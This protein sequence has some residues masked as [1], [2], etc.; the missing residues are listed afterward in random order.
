MTTI[1]RIVGFAVVRLAD[2]AR[3]LMSR[4]ET[5]HRVTFL[6][7]FED[8]RWRFGQWRAWRAFE[9]ARTNTPAYREFLVGY[10]DARVALQGLDPD[11]SRVPAT[12]KENYVKRFSIEQRCVGGRLPAYGVVIDESSGTS[13]MPNNWVRGPHERRAVKRVL[14]YSFHH[15]FGREPIFVI[16]AFALGPWATGMNV[17]MSF[18]DVAILKSVGPD[19]GK[20]VNTLKLFGP[21][22][23]YLIM[24][25]PPF[26]K[27]MI[28]QADVN[29]AGYDVSAVYGGEGMSE[30]MRAYLGRAFREIIGSYGASDLEINIAA[31]S[32]FT[33]A[34]RRAMAARADLRAALTRTEYGVLPMVFQYNPMDYA[35]E[36]NEHGEL[37]V[38]LCRAHN[39]SPK[40]RYDIHDLG[41]VLRYPDLVRR[42]ATVGMHPRD[43]GAPH[44][45]LPL[46]FHYGR[47]D[48]AVAYYGSKVTPTN[49]EEALFSVPGLGEVMN[50]FALVVDEDAEANKTLTLAI[51]LGEG[52]EAPGDR[53][54]ARAAVLE[55]L[56]AINQDYREAQRF[57]PASARP[58]LEFHACGTGPFEGGD[59]RLKKH[60]IRT[61]GA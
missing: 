29:W 11:F 17:S 30:G 58:R 20:I 45:D 33:I 43:L 56:A 34:L 6:P 41:H 32:P 31:E 52:R 8:T 14:Q 28:D 21:R 60:Y 36:T 4:S 44:L 57:M 48:L 51:E 47:S 49:V 15:L 53:E 18:V 54:A 46:L 42:M 1:L 16:N 38:T 10:P 22:Y 61:A 26:L 12:D 13:G 23:R 9:R 27:T 19:V 50:S 24:G 37:L 5:A 7:G 2:V 55:R 40:I 3:A 25:Y 39:A 59:I 35:I